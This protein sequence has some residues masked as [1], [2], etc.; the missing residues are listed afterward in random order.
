M[1]LNEL[2]YDVIEV[3]FNNLYERK[4]IYNFLLINKYFN[5]F[6]FRLIKII[7][8]IQNWFHSKYIKEMEIIGI[9]LWSKQFLDTISDNDKNLLKHILYTKSDSIQINNNLYKQII[10]KKYKYRKTNRTYTI[11]AYNIIDICFSKVLNMI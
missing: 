3:I 8:L 2:N 1:L 10:H 9:M 4:D 5:N 11:T 7:F 6:N